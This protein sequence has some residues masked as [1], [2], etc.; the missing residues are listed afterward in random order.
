MSAIEKLEQ[1]LAALEAEVVKL[2]KKGGAPNEDNHPWWE[3][4]YGTFEGDPHYEEAMELGRKY[5]ESFRP[6]PR[7]AKRSSPRNDH[8]RH[9]LFEPPGMAGGEC[10]TKIWI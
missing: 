8:S 4:I 10:C 9:G 5:R 2:K 7:K 1:R 3:K 6:K